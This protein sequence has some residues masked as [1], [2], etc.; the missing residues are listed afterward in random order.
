MLRAG[1]Q[2]ALVAAG[3]VLWVEAMQS[4]QRHD[5]E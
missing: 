5:N 1:N 3:L 4:P 2:V